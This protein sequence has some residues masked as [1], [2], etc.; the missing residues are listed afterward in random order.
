M[1]DQ[2]QSALFRQK[3]LDTIKS[4]E[5]MDHYLKVTTPGV[6]LLLSTIV[7]FLAGACIWGIFGSIRTYHEVLIVTEN[8]S[9]MIMIPE[10]DLDPATDLHTVVVDGQTA[11]LS[12]EDMRKEVLPAD[13]SDFIL[14]TGGFS[15]G[16]TVY[17]IPLDLE[18]EEGVCTGELLVEQIQPMSFIF[19]Q[20]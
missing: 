13:T 11:N 5:A 17:L 20:S 4:P 8:D 7:V 16:E 14:E 2:E 1:A 10:A 12:P 18:I 6:W 3:S 9:V 19:S 15:I